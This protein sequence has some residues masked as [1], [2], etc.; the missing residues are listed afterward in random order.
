MPRLTRRHLLATAGI[1]AFAG[2]SS[3]NSGNKAQFSGP[4]SLPT[5]DAR[6]P[7]P[8]TADAL[9]DEARSGG[10]GKDGIPSIDDPQFIRA[11]DADFLAPGDPVFGVDRDGVT[12]AY[13]QKILVAHEIVNDEL[14]GTPVAVTYCP[15]TGTVQGFERGNTEF[16]VSGTH[17]R[18]PRDVRP[19]DRDVVAPDPRH[20]DPGAVEREPRNSVASGV[21]PHLDDM[22][23]MAGPKPGYASPL[24]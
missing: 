3:R 17:Q 12:K 5:A 16:G 8:T 23:T 21:P 14:D 19:N 11:A 4:L 20:V 6:L 9:T 18:E 15:L 22:G 7:L 1:A 13:P 24:D 10:P 2:C